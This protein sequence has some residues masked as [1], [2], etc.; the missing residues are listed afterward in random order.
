M[1]DELLL[2]G[3][4]T[5]GDSLITRSPLP[6]LVGVSKGD[7][8]KCP[9]SV[10]VCVAGVVLKGVSAPGVENGLAKGFAL[11]LKRSDKSPVGT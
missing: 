10:L 9:L 11:F 2:L 1:P 7:L 5:N 6:E 8:L 3:N 4:D